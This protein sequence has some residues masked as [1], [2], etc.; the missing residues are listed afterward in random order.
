MEK[1]RKTIMMM[2]ALLHGLD[3]RLPPN[4]SRVME[5]SFTPDALPAQ[6]QLSAVDLA[7]CKHP[8]ATQR[9]PRDCLVVRINLFVSQLTSISRGR[10]TIPN[11]PPVIKEL[12]SVHDGQFL[13]RLTVL[14]NNSY[15]FSLHMLIICCMEHTYTI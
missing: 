15:E 5:Q 3:A 6:Q 2:L 13:L 14:L 7:W 8:L 11:P 12:P 10:S 1:G 9:A 4:K